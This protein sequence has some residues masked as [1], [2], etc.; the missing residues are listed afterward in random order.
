MTILNQYL[1]YN[2]NNS[3]SIDKSIE[4]IRKIEQASY[5]EILDYVIEKFGEFDN[6]KKIIEY[7]EFSKK[8]TIEHDKVSNKVCSIISK[9]GKDTEIITVTKGIEFERI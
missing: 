6:N 9:E 8:I 4:L 3:N 2:Y 5:D 1:L 7:P